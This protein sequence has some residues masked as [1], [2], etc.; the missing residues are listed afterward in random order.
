MVK[1]NVFKKLL[2]VK[3]KGHKGKNSVSN[4]KFLSE[5]IYLCYIKGLGL[6]VQQLWP[7]LKLLKSRLK[8]KVTRFKI[9]V[10]LERPNLIVPLIIQKLWLRLKFCLRWQSFVYA[11]YADSD[12][13]T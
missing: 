2:K 3:V 13:D 4:G 1:F 9:V 8:V 7:R 6:T 12:V 10:P 5:G 11:N